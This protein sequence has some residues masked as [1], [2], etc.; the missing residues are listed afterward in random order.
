MWANHIWRENYITVFGSKLVQQ[1]YSTVSCYAEV[2]LT[3]VKD[4]RIL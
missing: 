1:R 4:K 3:S 2:F